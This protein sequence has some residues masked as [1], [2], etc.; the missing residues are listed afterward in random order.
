MKT[1]AKPMFIKVKKV[2][3]NWKCA[4]ISSF[5]SA[6][7][8]KAVKLTVTGKIL[9]SAGRDRISTKTL[10]KRNEFSVTSKVD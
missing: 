8:M 7:C 1:Q 4:K 10:K 2:K 3:K 6:W 5:F 9:S